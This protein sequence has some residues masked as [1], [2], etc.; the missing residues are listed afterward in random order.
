VID[1]IGTQRTVT[2]GWIDHVDSMISGR[3]FLQVPQ[4]ESLALSGFKGTISDLD[5]LS[6]HPQLT[7]IS[8][9]D[10]SR[11]SEVLQQIEICRNIKSLSIRQ[12]EKLDEASLASICKMSHLETLT[13][14]RIAK[15]DNVDSQLT[16]S[17]P[18]TSIAWRP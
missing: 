2:R 4:L 6:L 3:H 9:G 14:H 12:Q 7:A 1:V 16:Q 15:A 13:I 17:L 8:L 5:Q 11:L 18:A 10:V